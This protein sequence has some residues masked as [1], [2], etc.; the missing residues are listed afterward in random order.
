MINPP[1]QKI[2]YYLESLDLIKE[3]DSL[4][5]RKSLCMHVCCGP[6]SCW[7]LLF[8]CPHFDLTLYFNNSNIYPES[9]FVRRLEELKKLLAYIKR[10]Y[11][12]EIKLVVKPYD[13]QNYVKDLLP[14]SNE[15]E[16]F[17]RCQ[18]CYEKRMAEAYDYAEENGFDYFTTVMTISRQKNSQ[19]MNL[20]GQEL[21]KNHKKTKYFYS[22]FKKDNGSLKGKE[23][24]ERYDLYNQLY[25]GCEFSIINRGLTLDDM[26]K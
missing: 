3:A 13:Y 1:K 17:N 23:I 25:C 20:I 10:D 26:S 15:P 11:G 16:G 19:I 22:D 6:C 21:E 4:K 9:E 12:Y 14:F 18:I 7:P 8:L 2:N 24:R 5:D